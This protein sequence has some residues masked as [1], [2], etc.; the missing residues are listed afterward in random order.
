MKSIPFVKVCGQTHLSSI[1]DSIA[2]GA[3]YCGFVFHPRSPRSISPG[4]AALLETGALKRVGVFVEQNAREINSIMKSANL[5]YAQLHGFQDHACAREIGA[6][7][8]IRVIWPDRHESS[9]ALQ[10]EIDS[11]ADDCAMYLL[12]AGQEGGG[13]GKRWDTA[14][15]DQLRFHHPWIL[16]GGL[17]PDNLSETLKCC[18]PD[19]IDLNSG[20][21]MAPG[22]K[23][24]DKLRAAFNTLN[25]K[26]SHK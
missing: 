17:S 4:R 19:G 21:E 15:A 3:R 24:A 25:H 20:V 22:L 16:A 5:D 2:L 14:H 23:C 26:S 8:V 1:D 12:D 7:R 18:N 6:D 13:S 11:W 9:D 10:A